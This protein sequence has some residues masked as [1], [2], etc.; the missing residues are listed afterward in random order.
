MRWSSIR[1]YP[2]DLGNIMACM[3]FPDD[4]RERT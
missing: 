3:L 2:V 4:A 1:T